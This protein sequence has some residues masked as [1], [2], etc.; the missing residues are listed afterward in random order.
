MVGMQAA[1]RMRDH[2]VRVDGVPTHTTHSRACRVPLIVCSR[3]PLA[4]CRASATTAAKAQ[5]S[6]SATPA[7]ASERAVQSKPA[8]KAA[9]DAKRNVRALEKRVV[10]LEAELA[11]PTNP[12]S[13]AVELAELKGRL[14]EANAALR[15]EKGRRLKNEGRAERVVKLERDV[16]ELV[17]SRDAAKMTSFALGVAMGATAA[18]GVYVAM[19]HRNRA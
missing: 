4:A 7:S 3:M 2:F 13:L 12:D 16:E 14:E 1:Q 9:D 19:L 17:S 11:S 5:R 6:A 15:A 8:A 10:S 18:C